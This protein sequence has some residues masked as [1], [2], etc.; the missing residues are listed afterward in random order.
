M[1]PQDSIIRGPT[2]S[3]F[4]NAPDHPAD[5]ERDN[6]EQRGES[7]SLKSLAEARLGLVTSH[8]D[9]ANHIDLVTN[10]ALLMPTEPSHGG[11]GGPGDSQMARKSLVVSN[12]SQTVTN[13][14]RRR[15]NR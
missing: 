1:Q 14:D 11:R 13:D 10:T 6:A 2:V 9:H 15:P 3:P 8:Q 5:A 7:E 12:P 4:E